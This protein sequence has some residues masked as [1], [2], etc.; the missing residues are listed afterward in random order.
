MVG[1]CHGLVWVLSG[2]A[3]YVMR[4]F[5]MQIRY[6]Y[7]HTCEPSD[8]FSSAA[9]LQ[10]AQTPTTTSDLMTCV[11]DRDPLADWRSPCDGAGTNTGRDSFSLK[12]IE[13][14][15]I[16]R[17]PFWKSPTGIPNTSPTGIPNSRE[18]ATA[19]GEGAQRKRLRANN[20]YLFQKDKTQL[21]A[22]LWRHGAEEDPEGAHRP[23]S[24]R[25]GRGCVT[26]RFTE[27][28][29]STYFAVLNV[30]A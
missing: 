21:R 7:M 6:T 20:K 1:V 19:E 13:R 5:G 4:C 27:W 12:L 25:Q 28:I 30:S 26:L 15:L 10:R 24:G 16:R 29:G 9:K 8:D 22:G 18:A 2:S 14:C 3:Y 11:F 17:P 23:G